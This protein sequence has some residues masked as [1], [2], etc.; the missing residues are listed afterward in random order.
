MK[1]ITAKLVTRYFRNGVQAFRDEVPLGKEYRVDTDRKRTATNFNTETW[2]KFEVV[3][4]PDIDA[5]HDSCWLP[6]EC[7]NIGNN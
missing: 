5:P 1:I 6:L 3:C 4:V 7:L 2:T